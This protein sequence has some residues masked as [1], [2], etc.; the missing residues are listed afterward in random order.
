MATFTLSVERGDVDIHD[1]VVALEQFAG[2]EGAFDVNGFSATAEMT[3]YEHEED[4]AAVSDIIKNTVLKLE[5]QD[6]DSWVKYFINSGV[7]R[8]PISTAVPAF[9]EGL[10]EEL[11][12]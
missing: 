4:M 8:E 1:V 11:V 5:I 10:V 2:L 6:E 3:W 7:H 12:Y 9:D